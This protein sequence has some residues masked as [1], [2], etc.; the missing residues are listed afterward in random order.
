M[1]EYAQAFSEGEEK[2][3]ESEVNALREKRAAD[4]LQATGQFL[5]EFKREETPETDGKDSK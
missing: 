3:P 2:K 1:S 5:E 4:E